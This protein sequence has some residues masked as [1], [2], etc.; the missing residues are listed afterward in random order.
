MKHEKQLG[1]LQELW[2]NNWITMMYYAIFSGSLSTFSLIYLMCTMHSSSTQIHT[3][4]TIF[5]NMKELGVFL[6]PPWMPVYIAAFVKFVGR[7][8]YMLH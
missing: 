1:G 8:L 7:Y 5:C 4:D 2:N 6:V 3:K